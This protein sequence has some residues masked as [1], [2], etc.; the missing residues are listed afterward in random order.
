MR[1]IDILRDYHGGT[2][3]YEPRAPGLGMYRHLETGLL[4]RPVRTTGR[5]YHLIWEDNGSYAGPIAGAAGLKGF[6]SDQVQE[7]TFVVA[8]RLGGLMIPLSEYQRGGT[9]KGFPKVG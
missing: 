3:R 9:R 5:D 6:P 1:V 2:W 7:D 8:N 4:V